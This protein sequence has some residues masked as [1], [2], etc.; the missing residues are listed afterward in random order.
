MPME[1]RRVWRRSCGE[2]ASRFPAYVTN[3]ARREWGANPD[4][5]TGLGVTVTVLGSSDLRGHTGPSAADRGFRGRQVHTTR[6]TQAAAVVT[7][8]ARRQR[9]VVAGDELLSP[10]AAD[11]HRI[12][13]VIRCNTR[14]DLRRQRWSGLPPPS[15]RTNASRDFPDFPG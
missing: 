2:V 8:L 11:A 10:S 13:W 1:P 3:A 4:A 12:L 5:P 14:V 7:P 9:H 6:G 15:A